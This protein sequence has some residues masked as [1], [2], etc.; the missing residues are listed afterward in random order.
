MASRIHVADQTT[1]VGARA[2]AA[3]LA[4]RYWYSRRNAT[5]QG[6]VSC[7]EGVLG[8]SE[9]P[10]RYPSHHHEQPAAFQANKLKKRTDSYTDPDERQLIEAWDKSARL[11]SSHGLV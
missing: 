3:G 7:P 6:T 4:T 11:S 5:G 2:V 9:G 10:V 1:P 8:L